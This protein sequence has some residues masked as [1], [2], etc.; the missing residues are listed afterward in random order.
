MRNFFTISIP[1]FV[2]FFLLFEIIIRYSGS[3]SD[4]AYVFFDEENSILKF[5]KNIKDTGYYRWGDGHKA[6]WRINNKSIGSQIIGQEIIKTGIP[7]F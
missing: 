5:D 7:D 1:T 3:V 6:N 4:I 2:L